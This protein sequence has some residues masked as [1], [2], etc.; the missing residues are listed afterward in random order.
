MATD[1]CSFCLA[2]LSGD[3]QTCPDCGM[4]VNAE[5]VDEAMRERESRTINLQIS[6]VNLLRMRGEFDDAMK[7]CDELLKYHPENV[8]VHILKGDVC[9]ERGKL[10]DAWHWY[11]LASDMRPEDASIHRKL[12]TIDQIRQDR[13]AHAGKDAEIR[14]MLSVSQRWRIAGLVGVVLIALLLVGMVMV[15]QSGKRIVGS[16][17]PGDVRIEAIKPGDRIAA[18][19]STQPSV[20]SPAMLQVEMTW[21][22]M[23]RSSLLENGIRCEDVRLLVD[24]SGAQ[25]LL[26]IALPASIDQST[27]ERVLTQ[28]PLVLTTAQNDYRRAR[29]RLL[30]LF[31]NQ[32]NLV[33]SGDID[34]TDVRL[35]AYENVFSTTSKP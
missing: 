24:P 33:F 4:P 20:V 1:F 11:R 6:R 15:V 25:L 3:V 30:K 9:F 32:W 14:R 5:A 16:V 13:A 17:R 12:Q 31:N 7:L 28:A 27:M 22:E 21:A 35:D 34:L 18:P 19:P 23:V 10:D 26:T 8:D 2:P 29:V